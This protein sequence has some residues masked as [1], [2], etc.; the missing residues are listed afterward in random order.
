MHELQNWKQIG[1]FFIMFLHGEFVQI[2]NRLFVRIFD[3]F[4]KAIELGPRG[5]TLRSGEV[6][7]IGA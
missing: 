2:F 7:I 5:T 3:R 4:F 6:T 1:N